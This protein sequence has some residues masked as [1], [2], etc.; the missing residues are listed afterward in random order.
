VANAHLVGGQ[1][2]RQ[3]GPVMSIDPSELLGRLSA[4]LK[5]DIAP[6]VGDEYSR[7]QTFMASVIL[8]RLSK[9]I[10]LA[11]D[12]VRAELD[13][14]TTLHGELRELLSDAPPAV[15]LAI[16][17]LGADRRVAVLDP[18]IE[19]LYAEMA[20]AGPEESS[21]AAVALDVVRPHLRRDIDRRM[22]IAK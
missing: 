16:E 17:T 5:A 8:E 12:H 9:Q 15:E 3:L 14:M 21:R 13:D 10:A 20:D 18:L 11:P 4:T 22:E 7:T 2:G 19:A 1:E 6:A